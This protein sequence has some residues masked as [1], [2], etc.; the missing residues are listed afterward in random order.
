MKAKT[1][2]S[3]IAA[4]VLMTMGATPAVGQEYGRIDFVGSIVNQGCGTANH[5]YGAYSARDKLNFDL[6]LNDCISDIQSVVSVSIDAVDKE[7]EKLGVTINA[8]SSAVDVVVGPS[9]YATSQLAEQPKF[10]LGGEGKAKPLD[11]KYRD[12]AGKV[13]SNTEE[14]AYVIVN[15]SYV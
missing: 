13:N 1:Y 11:I 3:A 9:P 5:T 14:K 2:F 8:Q 4:T 7:G 10:Y 6:Q 12:A 15:L